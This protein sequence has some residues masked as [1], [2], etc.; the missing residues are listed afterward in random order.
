MMTLS[1]SQSIYQAMLAH[2]KS[3]YP[4]EGCGLLAGADG[5]IEAHY[6]IDNRLN[7]P[8]AFEMEPAQLVTA[9]MDLEAKG[10]SLSAIYHAHPYGPAAPSSTD[11]AQANYPDSVQIIVSLNNPE[12]PQ[13]EGFQIKNG[14]VSP[15]LLKIV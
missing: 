3:V 1:I 2:L 5:R 8:T 9:V 13:T 7:S 14:R 4:V 15:V 11:I 10:L 12:Q 6:P